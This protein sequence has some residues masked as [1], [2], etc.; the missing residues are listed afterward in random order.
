MKKIVSIALAG[1][2][3]LGTAIAA[4]VAAQAAPTFKLPSY[5]DASSITTAAMKKDE[6]QGYDVYDLKIADVHPNSGREYV[7]TTYCATT[8]SGFSEVLIVANS[9]GNILKDKQFKNREI[10]VVSASSTSGIKIDVDQTFGSTGFHEVAFVNSGVMKWSTSGKKY[11]Y[12]AAT[13]PTWV[14][15]VDKAVVSSASGQYL[16][17]LTGSQTGR[18]KFKTKVK[19]LSA[20][21][22]LYTFCDKYVSSRTTCGTASYD[23]A[24]IVRMFEFDFKKSGSKH[25]I[26]RVGAYQRFNLEG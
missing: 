25:Y 20:D 2:L 17:G 24:P 19:G 16:A 18:A 5:C 8:K 14:K 15:D 13:V 11:T 12:K 1:V 23:L 3:A 22:G 6:Q 4:P 26:T 7:F 21:F 9:K 10:N